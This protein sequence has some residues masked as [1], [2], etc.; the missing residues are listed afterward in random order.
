MARPLLWVL[1]SIPNEKTRIP[2]KRKKKKKK[3]SE[4]KSELPCMGMDTSVFLVYFI[5]LK[6]VWFLIVVSEII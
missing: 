5:N 3:K 6:S 1:G 2:Q 4:T